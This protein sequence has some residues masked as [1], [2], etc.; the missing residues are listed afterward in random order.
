MDTH[1]DTPIGLR[2]F[3]HLLTPLGPFERQPELAVAVSGGADSMALCL[4]AAQWAAR[5]SGRINALTVDHGLRRGSAREAAM[6][7]RWLAEKGIAH[8]VLRW[9]GPK[10]T[11]GIQA[12]ARAARYA[13]LEARCR[14]QGTLHL[15]VAHHREDQAE[16]L[17]LRLGR[18]SGVDGLAGMATVVERDSVRIL[19]PLLTIPRSRLR[20]TLQARG[21]DWIEDPANVDP[22]YSRV[23]LRQLMP[24]LAREGLHSHRLAETARHMAHA[25][26]A[27]E[28]ATARLLARAVRLHPTGFCWLDP[29]HL[30]AAPAE[31]GMRALARSLMCVGAQ[32]Y[33]PRRDRLQRLH[34]A[35]TAPGGLAAARTLCGCRVLPLR[36]SILICRE[37]GAI[38]DQIE[39]VPG[40]ETIWDGRFC[41][42][43]GAGVGGRRW[44]L[45]CLGTEGWRQV[46]AASPA[47]RSTPIP[48][49]VRSSLPALWQGRRLRAVPHLNYGRGRAN[50]GTVTDCTVAF[51]PRQMLAGPGFKL[52]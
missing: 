45:R 16:T 35:L 52:V 43:F 30:A 26:V 33:P 32:T 46:V 49:A 48:P 42:R 36:G 39:A 40:G 13:L 3:D 24:T 25:R 23:R 29:G 12:A 17:L 38:T 4:L 31:V 15:L 51:Q 18:G 41:V 20:A 8:Q 5:R 7:G 50:A 28:D 1:I 22:V 10:P 37:V 27:L 44:E 14:R 11:T 9:R 21:Q 6:V 34:V 47:L 2:D 19:R